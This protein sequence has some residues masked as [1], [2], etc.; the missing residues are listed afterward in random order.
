MIDIYLEC[1]L[2]IYF[3]IPGIKNFW[4][5]FSLSRIIFLLR[6]LKHFSW[7]PPDTRFDLAKKKDLNFPRKKIFF[8][9]NFSVQ[10]KLFFVWNKNVHYLWIVFKS[11]FVSFFNTQAKSWKKKNF[12]Y[13][14]YVW[15][16]SLFFDVNKDSKKNHTTLGNCIKITNSDK[17]SFSF[18]YPSKL[19]MKLAGKVL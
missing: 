17:I 4:I 19:P 1:V 13:W 11:H 15:Q 8:C 7:K 10:K 6:M 18:S 2:T 14:N 5:F 3:K 16:T 9:L 12:V